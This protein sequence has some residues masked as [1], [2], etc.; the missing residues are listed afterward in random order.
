[1]FILKVFILINN[2]VLNAKDINTDYYFSDFCNEINGIFLLEVVFFLQTN[3]DFL[4]SHFDG[5]FKILFVSYCCPELKFEKI[6]Y[7]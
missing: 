3:F 7:L 5:F 1:M 2:Q 6:F 4:T